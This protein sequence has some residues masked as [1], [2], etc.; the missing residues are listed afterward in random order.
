M[1]LS[2]ENWFHSC[3]Y[4]IFDARGVSRLSRILSNSCRGFSI[5]SPGMNI[6][7]IWSRNNP[8]RSA[9][10]ELLREA[11]Y[12]LLLPITDA[13]RARARRR[14]KRMH[15]PHTASDERRARVI[16]AAC[17]LAYS[18]SVSSVPFSLCLL[19]CLSHGQTVPEVARASVRESWISR[20][21][22]AS[23]SLSR[24][25][26]LAFADCSIENS[27]CDVVVFTK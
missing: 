12:V 6:W 21:V 22:N 14:E 8:Q 17:V 24:W 23:S 25:S 2:S 16:V 11:S 26:Q 10:K 1:H 5:F 3:I 7:N 4:Y 20:C 19:V 27:T 9:I 18:A 15:R 13:Q